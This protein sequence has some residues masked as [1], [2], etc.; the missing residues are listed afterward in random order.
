MI[1]YVKD[2][3]AILHWYIVSIS[4]GMQRPWSAFVGKYP[5]PAEAQEQTKAGFCHSAVFSSLQHGAVQAC[6]KWQ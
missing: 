1:F 6:Y 4:Q 3:K 5:H 2:G